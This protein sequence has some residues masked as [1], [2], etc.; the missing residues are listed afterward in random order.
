MKR[1]AKG[2]AR[3][4]SPN[5]CTSVRCHRAVGIRAFIKRLA[6]LSLTAPA[7]TLVMV[8]QFIGNL[9]IRHPGTQKMITNSTNDDDDPYLMDEADPAKCK[10]IDSPLWEVVALQSHV[11]PQVAAAAKFINKSA[12]QLEWNIN[13]QL[14]NTYEDMFELECKKKVFVNVPLTFERPEKFNFARDVVDKWAVD[15]PSLQALLAYS[16]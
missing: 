1:L 11:L 5:A 10:A 13:D 16:N 12:P 6:R 14:E 2:R 4:R 8:M 9:M 15:D 3:R 7:N